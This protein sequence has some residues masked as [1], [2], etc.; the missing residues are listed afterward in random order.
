[1]TKSGVVNK[2]NSERKKEWEN[3]ICPYCGKG[4][5]KIES[6]VKQIRGQ[7][8][9]QWGKRYSCPCGC[10]NEFTIKAAES[11]LL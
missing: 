3:G 8:L 5:I 9:P 2:C 1:M 4:G 6:V 11:P 7:K 10:V